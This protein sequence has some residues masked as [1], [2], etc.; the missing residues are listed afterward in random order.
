MKITLKNYYL[1]DVNDLF[2]QADLRANGTSIHDLRR[3]VCSIDA[4]IIL[5]RSKKTSDRRWQINHINKQLKE[6][7]THQIYPHFIRDVA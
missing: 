7:A 2:M 6:L 4:G 1:L 5:L 3:M